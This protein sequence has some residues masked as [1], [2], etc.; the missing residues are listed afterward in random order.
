MIELPYGFGVISP[1]FAGVLTTI[2]AIAA[3]KLL[4]AARRTA[5]TVLAFASLALAAA[6]LFGPAV[7]MDWIN[8]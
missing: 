7:L 3:Y 4:T 8:P 6:G 5:G 1:F 2:A